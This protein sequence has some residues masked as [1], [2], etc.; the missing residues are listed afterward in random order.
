[1]PDISDLGG[2][3]PRTCWTLVIGPAWQASESFILEDLGDGDRTEAVALVGQITA[4][5]VDR[6]VLFAEGDDKIAQGIGF[7]CG[8]GSL[9]RCEEEWAVG[10][11]TEL[12]DQDAKVARGVTETASH[13]DAGNTSD[14]ERAK[15]L[16]LT[17]G[18]VS[19]LDEDPDDIS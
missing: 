4:D 17:V 13:L 8:L 15:G 18:G 10:I 1:L 12:M 3:R 5:I 2:G 14:E 6:E 7:G 19:G 16:V 9:G 11:L